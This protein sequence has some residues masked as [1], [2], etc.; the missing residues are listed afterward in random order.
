MTV[1]TRRPCGKLVRKGRAGS[2]RGLAPGSRPARRRRLVWLTFPAAALWAGALLP[3]AA[4]QSLPDPGA[5][6]P[7]TL[8]GAVARALDNNLELRVARA[9]T[10]LALAQLVGSRLRPNPSLAVEYLSNGDGR[11]S[12]TQD[13][14]LWGIRGY[15]M[16]AAQLEQERT[17][18]TVQDAER[19][20]RRDVVATYRELVFLRDRV[21]LLDSLADLNHHV[22]R[23]AQLAFEQGLGSELDTRLS[24]ATYQQSLLDRDAAARERDVREVDLARLLGDSLTTSYKLTDSLPASGLRFLLARAADSASARAVRYEPDE[25]EVDTLIQQALAGRPDVRAAEFDIEAQQASLAAARAAGKPPVAVGAIYGRNRDDVAAGAVQR[26]VT[27]NGFGLGLVVGLPVRNR[28]QGEVARARFAGAQATLRLANVKQ[29]VERDIR[30]SVGRV[31][32]A[33][34]QVE[35]LRRV[36]LPTN[37]SA[38][39]IAEAAFGRGQASIFEVLQVQRTYAQATT[40][41]LEATRQYATAMAQLEAAVG[42]PV[43]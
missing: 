35:T 39:R 11:V 4:A 12:V 6:Q 21:A 20:V 16:Q 29:A 15:R 36:V 8:E 19:L 23:V 42:T 38:L 33:A 7:I 5:P 1:V 22:A 34:S 14:Q 31:A 43:Q 2:C 40:A 32:L 17:R 27:D 41:L 30:V 3:P 18:Y 28:N 37:Q 26:T 9:D 25:A 13:L 24:L 10:G